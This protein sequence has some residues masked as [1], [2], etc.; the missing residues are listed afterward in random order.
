MLILDCD[1]RTESFSFGVCLLI[2]CYVLTLLCGRFV[3]RLLCK[4]FILSSV[5]CQSNIVSKCVIDGNPA[6]YLIYCTSIILF[7]VSTTCSVACYWKLPFR[8]VLTL[9]LP[10]TEEPEDYKDSDSDNVS[11]VAGTHKGI[12]SSWCSPSVVVVGHA[13]SI[14]TFS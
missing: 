12:T 6:C 4:F 2:T 5:F 7:P 14:F 11:R 9:L 8:S 13:N 3:H 10:S 1:S